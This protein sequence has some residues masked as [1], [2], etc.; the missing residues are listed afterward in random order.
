MWINRSRRSFSTD[1]V[2]SR[3]LFVFHTYY[4][5]FILWGMTDDRLSSTPS[6]AHRRGRPDYYEPYG[7]STLSKVSTKS[8][9]VWGGLVAFLCIPLAAWTVFWPL[10]LVFGTLLPI[11]IGLGNRLADYH[12][13]LGS[14][15]S[16][17]HKEKELLEALT[18]KEELTPALA[19]METSLTV[20]EADR[21]L[22]GLAQKGHLKI[23]VEG[24]G[25]RFALPNP[26][27]QQ[28]DEPS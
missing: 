9:L 10:L 12:D 17:N 14:L 22:S 16:A 2:F 23:R 3:N 19:A 28:L 8:L 15:H 6:L 18:R 20:S 4:Q 24:G 1:S 25:L 13:P 7:N 21:M 26:N 5:L 27:R 11:A